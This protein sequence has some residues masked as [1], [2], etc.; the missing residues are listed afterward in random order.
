MTVRIR[1]TSTPWDQVFRSTVDGIT[2]GTQFL[3]GTIVV[4][5]QWSRRTQFEVFSEPGETI[6]VYINNK[7]E[8]RF[9]AGSSRTIV[10]LPL[11]KGANYIYVKGQSGSNLILVN[12]TN[13]AT[14]LKGWSLE[15][16][17][18]ISTTVD[19]HQ[20]Q[21]DSK[22]GLRSVEHQIVW[23][24][25]LPPTRVFR[26]LAG[27][28]AVK[29]LINET[30]T[31]RGVNEVASSASNST[32]ITRPTTVNLEFYEPSVYL[33]FSNAHDFGGWEFNYWIP[34][35]CHASWSAFIRLANNL[36]NS[37]FNLR[38]VSDTKVEFDYFGM[39]ESAIFDFY[40]NECGILSLIEDLVGCFSNL[41][42]WVRTRIHTPLCM[43]M[44]SGRSLDLDVDSPIG[45]DHFDTSPLDGSLTFD[46][47]DPS[48]PI[49]DGWLG[50]PLI[51]LD[52]GRCFDSSDG[53]IRELIPGTGCPSEGCF[54]EP[55]VA[56]LNSVLLG[57]Q[58]DIHVDAFASLSI[59]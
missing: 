35:I 56:I 58:Q 15:Y 17:Q 21:L 33:V 37:I 9:N 24:K 18:G 41:R 53:M 7:L 23:Q 2:P 45:S 12:A 48:D 20:L 3:R 28:L 4:P 59:V 8:T 6:E 47:C 39:P 55:I 30:T 5:F 26:A 57:I 22:F 19:D 1:H 46:S 29:S 31:T 50:A 32:I 11:R 43:S 49:C 34:N 42:A 38:S 44:Y 36:D 16:W 54:E 27:K 14:F 25:M 51:P 52:S 10:N 13:Y 40:D